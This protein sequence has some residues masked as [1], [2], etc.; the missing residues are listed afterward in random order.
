MYLS[1]LIKECHEVAKSKGF[2]EGFCLGNNDSAVKKDF[3]VRSMLVVT[4]IAEAVE[5]IRSE[6]CE[7]KQLKNVHYVPYGKLELNTHIRE[8]IA[9]TF[10]RLMDICGGYQIED[11]EKDIIKKI[12]INKKRPTKHN[13]S[14]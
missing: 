7:R 8:E 10:I 3:T 2:W 1:Q 4:E 13:K 9:D 12:K 14:F 11:I 5:A 6:Q